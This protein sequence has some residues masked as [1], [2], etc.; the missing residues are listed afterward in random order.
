MFAITARPR[1]K[2]TSLLGFIMNKV[3][4]KIVCDS[5]N[6]QGT[7]LTTIQI[8]V[9]KWLLQEIN[10]HRVFS[11]SYNSARAIPSKT[12]RRE[13]D[14]A[15][16]IWI[17]NQPG[18]SGDTELRGIKLFIASTTWQ[19]LTT[20]IKLGHWILE[21]CGLHK[22]YANRW[23]EPIVWVDGVI[24][25]T[26]WDNFLKLRNHPSAQPEIGNLAKQID[27]LLRDKKPI[28]LNEGDWHLPY[29]DVEDL[30]NHPIEDLRL[31][32]A[33]RCARVSYGFRGT[34][35]SDGD[36]KRAKKL[37]SSV[38]PHVSPCEHIAMSPFNQKEAIEFKSGNFRNWVQFRQIIEA[39]LT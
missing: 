32:S 13:A 12:M 24:S 11:R 19:V 16:L 28:F 27:H 14:F 38:P 37:L 26:D 25:S 18:M 9:P 22:Q 3:S 20:T 10:T 33:G 31:I 1:Q 29:I 15:P 23:L 8:R 34:K 6:Y 17:A 4:A 30:C 2:K 21:F 7:R 36:L 5:T 39:R 35:D